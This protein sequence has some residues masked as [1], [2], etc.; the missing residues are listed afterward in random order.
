MRQL[1]V[2][3]ALCLLS[4]AAAAQFRCPPKTTL[5]P[6]ACGTPYREVKTPEG[7]CEVWWSPIPASASAPNGAWNIE[8]R[9]CLNRYCRRA[10]VDVMKLARQVASH[11]SG[12]LVGMNEVMEQLKGVP[13]DPV[14]VYQFALLKWL[15]CEDARTNVA[16]MVTPAASAPTPA[17]DWCGPRPTPPVSS[18]TERWTA[19]GGTLYLTQDGRIR[20][21][22]VR[23][24]PAGTVCVHTGLRVVVGARIHMPI[25]G[26]STTEVTWC[27][28]RQ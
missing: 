21:V 8:R 3:I 15:A 22:S 19:N 2:A 9:C 14:E 6:T 26:G 18:T 20:S 11:A 5:S 24:V 13:T 17:A 12:V 23:T 28:R 7:E 1:I 10:D 4:S 16:L 25:V 27:E